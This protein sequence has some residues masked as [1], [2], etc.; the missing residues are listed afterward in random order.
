MKLNK[1]LDYNIL[2]QFAIDNNIDFLA[3]YGSYYENTQNSNSDLDI[4]IDTKHNI[5]SGTI[6]EYSKK[7]KRI[8]KIDIDI[9]TPRLMISSLIC[10][11]VWR[12]KQYEIIY[13][14]PVIYDYE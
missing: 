13:G 2:R 3:I 4:I 10:G 1:S 9:I 6:T 12:L 14:N 11:Y 5:D 7:L 8:L